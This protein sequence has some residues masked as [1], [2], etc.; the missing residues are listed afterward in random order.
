MPPADLRPFRL[1]L[2][3]MVLCALAL[4]FV[5]LVLAA[6]GPA[7]GA[8]D[9]QA[10]VAESAATWADALAL[11]ASA[12]AVDT[13]G[14]TCELHGADFDD[15]EPSDRDC[16]GAP[17]SLLPRRPAAAFAAVPPT[18]PQ[19]APPPLLRPPRTQA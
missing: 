13:Q 9:S 17:L 4:S 10:P 12:D 3:S 15:A 2:R 18:A 1:I 8:A 5:G 7:A 16:L 11:A 14:A 19:C 6:T